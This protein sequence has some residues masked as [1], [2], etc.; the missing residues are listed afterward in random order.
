MNESIE[1]SRSANSSFSLRT[2]L[3][4][5]V[6]LAIAA[7]ILRAGERGFIDISRALL[8][9]IVFVGLIQQV[10][11]PAGADG[12]SKVQILCRRLCLLTILASLGFSVVYALIQ[13]EFDD[14]TSAHLFGHLKWSEA[15]ELVWCFCLL[16]GATTAPWLGLPDQHTKSTRRPLTSYA[17]STGVVL[18]LCLYFVAVLRDSIMIVSLVDIATNTVELSLPQPAAWQS[19][20]FVEWFGRSRSEFNQFLVRQYQSWPLLVIGIISVVVAARSKFRALPTA[21]LVLASVA[22]ALPAVLNLWWLYDGAAERLFPHL[23]KSTWLR[24]PT[25]MVLIAFAIV[26]LAFYF[27]TR[28]FD[29][30]A[31]TVSHEPKWAIASDSIFVGIL[32]VAVGFGGVIEVINEYWRTYTQTDLGVIMSL[33]RGDGEGQILFRALGNGI[34][35]AILYPHYYYEVLFIP[36]GVHW[37]WCRRKFAARQGYLRWPQVGLRQALLMP[38]LSCLIA[39]LVAAS[40]P[41][42]LAIL[43]VY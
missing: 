6:V 40:V 31:A 43:H 18:S 16:L 20:H 2:L 35:D 8:T 10:L 33:I 3:L 14:E 9:G 41:F 36:Y 1:R 25:D 11:Q 21:M 34:R 38:L 26:L 7:A 30:S 24:T 28:R 19:P 29:W 12:R 13:S 17:I 23:I 32:F 15:S 42:G 27:A 4:L 22:L 5:V 37:L 39:I